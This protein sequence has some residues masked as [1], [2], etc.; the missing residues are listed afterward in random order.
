MRRKTFPSNKSTNSTRTSTEHGS[1]PTTGLLLEDSPLST[2]AAPALTMMRRRADRS[3]SRTSPNGNTVLGGVQRLKDLYI[4]D[5]GILNKHSSTSNCVLSFPK[6]NGLPFAST[7]SA[8]CSIQDIMESANFR[9]FIMPFPTSCAFESADY[10]PRD[11]FSAG[12]LLATLASKFTSTQA[13]SAFEH[14]YIQPLPI[15]CLIPND[16]MRLRFGRCEQISTRRIR[17]SVEPLRNV[18]ISTPVIQLL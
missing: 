11:D 6:E 16:E 10:S 2:M 9:F 4:C 18:V 3:P 17:L 8:P 14:G 13:A 12:H 5:R 7:F 15:R 1:Q